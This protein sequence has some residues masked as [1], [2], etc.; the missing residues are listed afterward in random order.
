MQDFGS[1]LREQAA[2]QKRG[3]APQRARRPSFVTTPA[4]R[5]IVAVDGGPGCGR[6]RR[7]VAALGASDN[8]G[9]IGSGRLSRRLQ[10]SGSGQ[11]FGY[12]GQAPRQP[13][14]LAPLD[15]TTLCLLP[16]ARVHA[17]GCLGCAGPARPPP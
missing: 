1:G 5:E 10:T 8:A 16:A 15:I 2:L 17:P 7:E 12:A 14:P 6:G 11:L 9:V 13:A 3:G 4:H